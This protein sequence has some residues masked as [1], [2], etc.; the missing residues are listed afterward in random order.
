M[1]TYHTPLTSGRVL[2]LRPAKGACLGLR[3]GD[4]AVEVVGCLLT[5]LCAASRRVACSLSIAC[6][7]RRSSALRVPLHVIALDTQ[8]VTMQSYIDSYVTKAR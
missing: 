6:V 4:A 7:P 8:E 5:L 2:D 1:S 3:R